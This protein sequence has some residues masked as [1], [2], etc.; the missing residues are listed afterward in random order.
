MDQK[1]SHVES[2]FTRLPEISPTVPG[3]SR[4]LQG[5]VGDSFM[6]LPLRILLHRADRHLQKIRNVLVDK[7]H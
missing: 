5:F 6:H 7:F 3:L 4:S 2:G 1:K